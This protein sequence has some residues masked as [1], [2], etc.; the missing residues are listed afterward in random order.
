MRGHT[1]QDEYLDLVYE[2]NMYTA[3][4]QKHVL[5]LLFDPIL[6]TVSYTCILIP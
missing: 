6:Y 1:Q 2:V 3:T 5:S 4:R